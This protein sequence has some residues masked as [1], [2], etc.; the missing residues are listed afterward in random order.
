LHPPQITFAG[1]E[2]HGVPFSGSSAFLHSQGHP[3]SLKATVANV[4]FAAWFYDQSRTLAGHL[5]SVALPRPA[6]FVD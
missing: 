6:N 4:R 5:P 1:E 2:N 3:R